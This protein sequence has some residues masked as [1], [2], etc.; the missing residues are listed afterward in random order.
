MSTD[1]PATG[2]F[3]L[4]DEAL[5]DQT[6]RAARQ[7]ARL[8]RNHNFHVADDEASHRLINAME[9]GSY[10]MPHR[11]L[12]PAKDETFVVLRGTFGLLLFDDAG[13]ITEARLLRAGGEVLGAN[14][15]HGTWHSLVSFE[16]GSVFLEAKGGP[17][18]PLTAEERAPWAP[19]EG[20]P[21]VAPY[22]ASME[23]RFEG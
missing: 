8:R 15:P 18:V 4:I 5:L 19:S 3:T 22:L 13:A 16:P 1:S 20:D 11:H 10:V 21:G 6:S 12:H 23:G 9:P 7:S 17:Y 2:R 14:V